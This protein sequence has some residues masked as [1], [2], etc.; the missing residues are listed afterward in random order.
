[1]FPP[2]YTLPPGSSTTVSFNSNY[3]SFHDQPAVHPGC[4]YVHR[5]R[6]HG[7]WRHQSHECAGAAGQRDA[8]AERADS[9]PAVHDPTLSEGPPC[10]L[11]RHRGRPPRGSSS[12]WREGGS[13]RGDPGQLVIDTRTVNAPYQ[14][15]NLPDVRGRRR[16]GHARRGIRPISA[17]DSRSD[18]NAGLDRADDT[19]VRVAALAGSGTIDLQGTGA[20]NDTTSLTVTEPAGQ[21]DQ[22]TGLIDGLGQLISQ[23]ETGHSRPVPSTSAT[24]AASRSFSG[25][26]SRMGR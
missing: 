18:S 5:E 8:P 7:Q 20:A 26:S 1:M 13:R 9:R 16:H 25:H 6:D 14:G 17:R 19:S 22:F 4:L 23:E 2:F 10:N 24:A 21:S 11:R 3:N 12:I 15:F